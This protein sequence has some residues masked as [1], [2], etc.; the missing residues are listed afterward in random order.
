T[1]NGEI[2]NFKSLRTQLEAAGHRFRSDSDAEVVIY[3]YLEWGLGFL[4]RLNG[5]F[6][7]AIWDARDETLLLARDRLGI[8]PLY[9]ADTPSGLA[10]ASEVKA[11]LAIPGIEREVDL[12]ALDQYLTFLWTPDPRT[13]FRGIN[14]LPPAHYLIYRNGQIETFEYWDVE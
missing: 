7:L 3:A 8:K 1:Y 13:I 2:Y 10:F 11:I 9:Y 12:A 14:K 6:A 5:M 4:E